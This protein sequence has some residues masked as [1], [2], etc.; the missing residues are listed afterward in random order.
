MSEFDSESLKN[1]A[2]FFPMKVIKLKRKT[3]FLVKFMVSKVF[4]VM[5]EKKFTIMLYRS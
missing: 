4:H 3:E 1:R 5:P 2:N